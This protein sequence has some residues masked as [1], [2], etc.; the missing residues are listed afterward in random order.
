MSCGIL[1]SAHQKWYSAYIHTHVFRINCNRN[2]GGG[3]ADLP[4]P[5]ANAYT[6]KKSM[7][8]NSHNFWTFLEVY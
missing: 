8:G 6:C 5:R 2:P 1:C 4:P 3:G 7:G